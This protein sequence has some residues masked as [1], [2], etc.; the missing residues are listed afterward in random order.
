MDRG[1][2]L[3]EGAHDD[4]Y[5]ERDDKEVENG[6]E[7]CAPKNGDLGSDNG[8][9]VLGDNS[10]GD[11]CL[12]GV[13]AAFLHEDTDKGVDDVGHKTGNDLVERTSDHNGDRKI[14]HVAAH[15]EFTEV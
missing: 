11:D 12:D 1:F 9:A 2:S 14:E 15:D 13:K 7:P 8:H 4:E 6:L 10:G 5:H 3:G